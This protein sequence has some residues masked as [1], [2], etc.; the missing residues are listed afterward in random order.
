MIKIMTVI[1]TAAIVKAYS[2]VANPVTMTRN[3][4]AKP[5]K[6]KKSNL[7]RAI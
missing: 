1:G 2:A 5:R 3:W 7:R 4:T 6:K